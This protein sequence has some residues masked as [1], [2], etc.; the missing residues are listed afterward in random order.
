MTADFGIR[1]RALLADRGMSLRGAARALRYDVAYLSRVVNGRQHPSAQLAA[2]LDKLLQAEGELAALAERMTPP[3]RP[4]GK[5]PGPAS[6]I[7][8]M[9]ESAAY[10]LVH[11]DRYGGDTAAPA[12]V[13]VWRSAQSKLDS[14]AIPDRAQRRYLSAVS[15]AAQVAGWLLF[16]AGDW[17]AARRAFLEAH[18]L[19][20][21]AGDR[22]R[23][24]FALDMLAML[25]T[26]LSRPG[27]TRRIAEE[28]LSERRIPPRVALLARM[29]RGRAQAQAGDR[30]R[31]L[32][33]LDAA[34]GGLEESLHPR[35]P[36]W[37]WWV[38]HCEV[39]GHAGHALLSLGNPEAAV[40]KLRSVLPQATPRG[41]MLYRIGLLRGYATAKAWADAE[42]ELQKITTLLGQ[43]SSGRNRHLLREALKTADA[44]SGAPARLRALCGET[45]ASL[46][47]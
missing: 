2:G 16:D 20:R 11:A 42:E 44:A 26:E 15:E 8:R 36:E 34:H 37:T 22:P 6:D 4:D 29:R 5:P 25:D 17:D 24:W 27:G 47:A 32:A 39:T 1:L 23:Q 12:A 43:I 45:A 31:A 30:T 7:A 46:A 18:M 28:L 14:G 41:V 35:D 10:L 13:Q 33:D 38:N 40:R 19:A 9:Q 21:H 3:A